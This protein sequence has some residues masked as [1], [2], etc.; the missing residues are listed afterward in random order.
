MK[1]LHLREFAI[2]G[3]RGLRKVNLEQ[4][5]ELKSLFLRKLCPEFKS[6]WVDTCEHLKQIEI[7]LT[8]ATGCKQL[9]EEDDH[10][11]FRIGGSQDRPPLVY[12]KMMFNFLKGLPNKAGMKWKTRSS[13]VYFENQFEGWLQ[14][15]QLVR[16]LFP[17]M[18]KIIRDDLYEH[19]QRVA[20]KHSSDVFLSKRN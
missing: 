10:Y 20:E 17:F 4:C 14:S 11:K 9:L 13:P 18:A 6:L 3:F 7:F 15:K 1:C 19:K 12:F 2:D 16:S 5:L 8:S